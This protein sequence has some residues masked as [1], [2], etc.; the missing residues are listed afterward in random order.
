MYCSTL[1]GIRVRAASLELRA[2]GFGFRVWGL[3]LVISLW[4]CVW[5]RLDLRTNGTQPAFGPHGS[6]LV[7]GLS[8]D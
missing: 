6:V 5:R 1:G 8:N 3:G 7:R 2:Q 4:E